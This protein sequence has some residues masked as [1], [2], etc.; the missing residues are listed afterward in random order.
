MLY[1]RLLGGCTM[2]SLTLNSMR[3]Y[4]RRS[5][6]SLNA[7]KLH[8]LLAEVDFRNHLNNIGFGDRVSIGGWI[9]RS[10]GPDNF[11][12]HTIAMFPETIRPRVNYAENRHYTE[13]HNGLHSV[14]TIFHQI[15]IRGYY[16]VPV[17]N[18]GQISWKA[19]QLGLPTHQPFVDFPNNLAGFT[20]RPRRYNFLQYNTEVRGIPAGTVP[21]EF[22]KENLR[23]SFQTSL[24]C[25][26]SDIDGIFWG[27]QNA[28]PIEI[29]EKTVANDNKIGDYFGLD[30]GPF[31]K[32]AFYTAS[33][34]GNLHSIFIVREINN[35]TDRELTQ[36]W[37]ITFERLSRYA[38]WVPSQGGRSMTGSQSA[39]VKIPKAEFRELTADALRG[40]I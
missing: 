24:L 7:N 22:T 5:L 4:L 30:L 20:T 36:W 33:R 17:I 10:V 18:N 25:E 38:S 19:T 27:Q 23:V 13:P 6:S 31:T 35:T 2:H 21:E 8:G 34:D 11:G 32:L 3:D 12:H 40:L 37:F 29:K 1:F 16:C 15:G 26:I 39:V 14:C 9:A 28:Y